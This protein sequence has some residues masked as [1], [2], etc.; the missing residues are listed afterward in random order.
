MAWDGGVYWGGHTEAAV[1]ISI[2][3]LNSGLF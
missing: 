1:D 2:A 3:G